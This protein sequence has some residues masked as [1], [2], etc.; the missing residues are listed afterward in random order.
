MEQK[1]SEI[2]SSEAAA[3][4]DKKKK[5]APAILR[6]FQGMLVGVGGILPGI[7]GGVLCAIFGLYQPMMEFLAHP[8]KNFKTHIKLLLPAGIGLVIGFLGLAKL[9]QVLFKS[10]EI[11]ATCIFVGLILGMLPS[12]WRESGTQGRKKSSFV[13]MGIG[14]AVSFGIL[15]TLKLV[16]SVN[17]T[18]NVFWYLISGVLFGLGIVVPGMSASSPLICL[19]LM[20]PLLD[21]AGSFMDSIIMFVSGAVTF[22]EAFSMMRFDAAI[23]FFVGIILIFVALSKL[24]SFLIG[25]FYSQ[26]YHGIFGVVIGTTLPILIFEI[27]ARNNLLIKILCIV[28]GFV[29]AWLL[30]KVS[31]RLDNREG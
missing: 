2:H 17:I 27:D 4:A 11:I 31:T 16:D 26:F 13:T 1:N 29:G 14:F 18:P 3:N 15:L 23:P 12:L 20:E 25:K 10:N 7:S 19:G 21:V 6:L 30:D 9:V 22:S 28:G 8:I 24:V 5:A